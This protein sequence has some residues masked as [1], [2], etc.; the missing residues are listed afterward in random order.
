MDLPKRRGLALALVMIIITILALVSIAFFSVYQSHYSLVR[1]AASSARATATTEAIH[2]YVLYR[3]EHDRNWAATPFPANS[4]D[5]SAEISVTEVANTHTLEGELPRLRATFSAE[6]LNNLGG[7]LGGTP[8]GTVLCRL[9]CQT[10]GASKRAKFLLRVAPLFDASVLT[11]G[12]LDVNAA[13]LSMRS[14]DPNRNLLRSEGDIFVPD[15]LTGNQSRFLQPDSNEA[16]PK[17]MLW[18]KGQIHSYNPGN[19]GSSILDDP[20]KVAQASQNITGK[21]VPQAESHFSI[22]DL[23][24][25]QLRVPQDNVQAEVQAGR[26][27]F[28]RRPADVN[29]TVT[30]SDGQDTH[31][32]TLTRT[33]EV[34]VLEYYSDPE[35]TVP[36][37]IYR[38]QERSEDLMAQTAATV[39]IVKRPRRGQPYTKT[40]PRTTV[41]TNS[42]Q[43]SGYGTR[44]DIQ[45][46]TQNEV[47]FGPSREV[48]FDLNNQRVTAQ[49]NTTVTIPGDFLLTSETDTGTAPPVLDLLPGSGRNADGDPN[50]AVLIADGSIKIEN[51]VTEGLGTLIARTGDVAIQPIDTRQVEV[52]ANS[53]DSGL[54]VFAGGNISLTNPDQARSWNFKGLVYARGGVRMDGQGSSASFEGSVVSLSENGGGIQFV[55]SNAI[56]F[57]Y[58]G[59]LLDQFVRSLP[60]QRIQLEDVYWRV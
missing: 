55:D 16:D 29:F 49:S 28:A 15:I 37:D 8:S 7:G 22:Y 58:N 46:Q 60:S 30:Y 34:D 42:L 56:E 10:A 19:A 5:S 25:D 53:Q 43:V 12:T 44:Q 11:R 4:T 51:G 27:N 18:A 14:R 17:G 31:S 40:L 32:E 1:G 54:V 52:H 33:V 48:V 3:L 41:T 57:I 38:G 20:T 35:G 36:D 47:A 50:R 39:E 21:V 6:V 13:S 26:W 9:N 2:E 59:A 23:Q 24:E 45:A